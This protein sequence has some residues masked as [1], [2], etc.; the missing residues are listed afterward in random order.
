MSVTPALKRLRHEDFCEFETSLGH[1]ERDL[2]SISYTPLKKMKLCLGP[3][4]GPAPHQSPEAAQTLTLDAVH[5]A[6]SRPHSTA[7]GTL[8]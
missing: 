2:V 8:T 7:I 3:Q 5:S 6:L 4:G 1:I